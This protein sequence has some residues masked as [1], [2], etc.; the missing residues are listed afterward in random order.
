MFYCK[1]SCHLKSLSSLAYR[2]SYSSF[3]LFSVFFGFLFLSP[4]SSSSNSWSSLS[5]SS[6]SSP[7]PP[8]FTSIPAY[9]PPPPLHLLPLYFPLL[10][11]WRILNGRGLPNCMTELPSLKCLSSSLHSRDSH[12][13]ANVLRPSPSGSPSASP[14]LTCALQE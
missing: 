11:L 3:D 1:L 14:T 12:P 6:S 10:L 4:S 2:F 8:L 7:L 5:F 9:I 13:F